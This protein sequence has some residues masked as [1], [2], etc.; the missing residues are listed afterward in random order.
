MTTPKVYLAGPEVFLAEAVAA[1]LAK[2]SLCTRYGFRGVFPLDAQ[3]DLHG[4]SPAEQALR[5]SRANEQLI[6][7]CQFVVANLTPFRGPSADAG[8]AYE[9]GVASALGIPVFA[10]TNSGDDFAV[11]SVRA[12]ANTRMRS[13]GT[14]EDERGM[15]IEDFG[16]ADNLMLIGAIEFSG[17]TLVSRRVPPERQFHDLEAF[18]DCL[19]AASISFAAK[20]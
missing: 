2:K 13:D 7:D 12:S 17:G 10:Y 3:L 4:L 19:R 20:R 14:R 15:L 1:G 5:I 9:M 6:R 16:L 11:R 8:T 18:E